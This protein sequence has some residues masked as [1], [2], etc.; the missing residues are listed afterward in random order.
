MDPTARDVG[1]LT[2][3]AQRMVDQRL[4]RALA[5]KE[6]VDAGDVLSDRDMAFLEEVMADA[7]KIAPIVKRNPKYVDIASRMVSL[8]NEI[9]AKALENERARKS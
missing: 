4:P 2:A 3:L 5:I 8:Y 7:A 9:T 6:R 1:V